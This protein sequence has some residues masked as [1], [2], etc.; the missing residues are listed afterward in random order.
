MFLNFNNYEVKIKAIGWV[1]ERKQRKWL[2][3]EYTS[4]PTVSTEGLM[5]A[6]II[7]AMEVWD[8]ATS[9]IPEALLQNYYNKV[10]IPINME[11]VMLALLEVIELAYY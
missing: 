3:K 10:D 4:S 11:V 1:D 7:D 9:D 5:L 2:S 6:C 8:V